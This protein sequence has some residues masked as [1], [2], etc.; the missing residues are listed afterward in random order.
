MRASGGGHAESG[1]AQ[2][3]G[4][5]QKMGKKFSKNFDGEL[6]NLRKNL[7]ANSANTQKNCR[8]TLRIEK[9]DG[10]LTKIDNIWSMPCSRVFVEVV[11]PS[12][13]APD[14]TARHPKSTQSARQRGTATCWGA[15]R[16]IQP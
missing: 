10:A 2:I 12:Q 16:R 11:S 5:L 15:R 14:A 8:Y 1:G 3:L 4:A 13:C 7:A 6:Q 9:L